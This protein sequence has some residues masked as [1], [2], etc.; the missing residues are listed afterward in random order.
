VENLRL[1]FANRPL[2]ERPLHTGVHRVVREA[3]GT[4]GVGDQAQGALLA[5][6]CVDRRG[7][8]LQVAN[9]MRG[10]HVNGRPIQRMAL[11]RAGDA[12]HVD[13]AELR[14]RSA[15]HDM[16]TPPPRDG[17]VEGDP[18]IVLRG[19]G[20]LHHG[21]SFP[22]TRPLL[23][24]RAREAALRIDDPAFAERH[25]QIELQGDNVLLRAL[26]GSEG[27]WVNGNPVRNALLGAGDQ[28]VFGPQHRYVVEIPWVTAKN[29]ESEPED[30]PA[31]PPSGDNQLAQK[32]AMSFRHWPWLLLA[33]ALLASALSALLMF[34]SI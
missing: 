3:A 31:Q 11:L 30:E 33:A 10:V 20:G 13:G 1:H 14:V 17:V 19:V 34:G 7:L 9:G 8:W 5:R 27:S 2:P 21:R 12:I 25:A 23:V 29:A 6:I 15:C 16:Q 28:L 18:R 22:L 26:D 24:G 4:V 32:P